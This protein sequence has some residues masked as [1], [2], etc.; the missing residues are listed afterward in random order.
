MSADDSSLR[1][2]LAS[3]H[4]I[5]VEVAGLHE[6]S[7][8]HDRAL[9]YCLELTASE[10]AF[11]GLLRDT[12]VGVVASGRPEISDRVMDVA[13]IKGFEPTPSFYALFH[14]MALRSSVVGVVIAEKRSY[15]A[16]D[17][18]GDAHSVG[19][20]P[21][22]PPIRRFLGVPLR[23]GTTV[24]GMIGVANKRPPYGPAD[25]QLLSTFANQVAVAVDNARLYESQR[26]MIA[27]LRRLNEKGAEAEPSG[28]PNPLTDIQVTILRL[29]AAGLSNREIAGR[30]HLSENTVKSHVQQIFRKLDVSNRVEAALRAHRERWL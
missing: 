5:S 12:R 16:N 23:V 29:I 28:Q 15:L 24:T 2:Q 11:T 3:L 26:Q 27:E 13:A 8:I 4:S 9:G 17:V 10:F 7:A 22:H 14:L 21:G 25:E 1:E 30:L 20:P 19:Q 6:L 18:S